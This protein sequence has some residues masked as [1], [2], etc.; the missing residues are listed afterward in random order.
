MQ[1]H[2][3]SQRVSQIS[4]KMENKK[5]WKVNLMAC[6][7]HL[8]LY[9]DWT[10]CGWTSSPEVVFL[11]SDIIMWTVVV[12]VYFVVRSIGIISISS[13]FSS[14]IYFLLFHSIN[15]PS[16]IFH[17][18]HHS[19]TLQN[20]CISGLKLYSKAIITIHVLHIRWIGFYSKLM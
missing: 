1:I 10:F 14:Y 8:Q 15:T 11:Y 19:Q 2:Q 20:Y 4:N 13:P 16:P 12:F 18:A 6:A 17:I 5:N 3:Y 9:E 7:D